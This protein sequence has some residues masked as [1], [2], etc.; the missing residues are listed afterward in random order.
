[1]RLCF[2][3]QEVHSTAQTHLERKHGERVFKEK[4]HESVG[5]E[6]ELVTWRLPIANE[7]VQTLNLTTVWQAVKRVWRWLTAEVVIESGSHRVTSARQ[8]LVNVLHDEVDGNRVLATY[9][10]NI[11]IRFQYDV[12]KGIM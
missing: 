12:T 1:M 4:A 2:R 10:N 3:Q 9:T 7:R 5:V 8:L 11:N 6:D